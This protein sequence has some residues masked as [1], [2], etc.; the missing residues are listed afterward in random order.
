[1]QGLGAGHHCSS[2]KESCVQ[3]N[4]NPRIHIKGFLLQHY[5]LG[6]NVNISRLFFVASHYDFSNCYSYSLYLCFLVPKF[7]QVFEN[8]YMCL[9]CLDIWKFRYLEIR[10]GIQKCV[11]LN[12]AFKL[13]GLSAIFMAAAST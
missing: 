4:I 7:L 11:A 8:F 6:L 2:S 10:Y 5:L 3:R 13:Q 12:V 9:R 1:M